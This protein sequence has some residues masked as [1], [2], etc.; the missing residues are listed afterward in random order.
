VT[1]ATSVLEARNIRVH[2]AG[3]RAVDGVDVSLREGEILGLI[4][5]NGAGKTTLVN[6]LSG[7][8]ALTAGTITLG[9]AGVHSWSAN[10]LARHGLCR[11]FQAVRLFPDL[12]VYENV[13]MGALGVGA[14]RR[15]A[16]E[17][18]WELLDT[19]G[20]DEV[21]ERIAADVPHGLERRIGI[22]RALA[23]KPR[24]LLLDE[25][26]AGLHEGESQ[27]LVGA[28]RAIRDGIGCGL[29]VIEHDMDLIMRLCERIQVL[30]HGKTI[31]VGT[32]A[33]IA[34]DPT[35]LEAYLGMSADAV[36]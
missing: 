13:E 12:T 36:G 14:S 29:M 19:M 32:P 17:T 10:R 23:T 15:E 30:D 27:E 31:A 3:L 22:A 4:G 21:A 8:Q 11:T 6:A 18:A 20:L 26:G 9:G 33:E 34:Q 2:F 35:V 24:F 1:A 7:F 16:A 25:P 28:L 5:P